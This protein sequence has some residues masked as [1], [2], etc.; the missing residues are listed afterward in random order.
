MDADDRRETKTLW[1]GTATV[2]LAMV[3]AAAALV[4]N[5]LWEARALDS[6][7]GEVVGERDVDTPTGSRPELL[8]AFRTAGGDSLLFAEATG[9][10]APEVGDSVTVWYS[11][12][13]PPRAVI[14]R[15]RFVWPALLLPVG[16]VLSAFGLWRLRRSSGPADEEFD[17][18]PE[19]P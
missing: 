15:Q 18:D 16:L 13:N 5:T 11:D 8:V 19:G 10:L 3:V 2:G 6:A 9:M 12:G 1:G 14:A 7:A 17:F 4:G